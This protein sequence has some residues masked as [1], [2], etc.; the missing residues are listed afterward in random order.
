MRPSYQSWMPA[1]H[2][3]IVSQLAVGTSAD[4]YP[5][6]KLMSWHVNHAHTYC[7]T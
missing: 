3:W 5:A 4:L 7:P 1:T 6:P 2:S